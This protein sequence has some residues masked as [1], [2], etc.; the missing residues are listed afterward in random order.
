MSI[1]DQSFRQ[2]VASFVDDLVKCETTIAGFVN[3]TM[4]AVGQ[5]R[6]LRG[7]IGVGP[8]AAIGFPYGQLDMK[9]RQFRPAGNQ[10]FAVE[11]AM[12]PDYPTSRADGP[13]EVTIVE[14]SELL[15]LAQAAKP[16]EIG[17]LFMVPP[18]RHLIVFG[19]VVT[20]RGKVEVPGKHVVIFAR[21]LR[22]LADGSQKALLDASA[23]DP[24]DP[25]IP[26][27]DY[28]ATTGTA[29]ESARNEK[30][31]CEK[32]DFSGSHIS[33]TD[34][35]R[36]PDERA[37]QGLRGVDGK[38]GGRS[39][40]AIGPAG[41]DVFIVADSL[42]AYSDLTLC[43]SG[44]RG[45]RG[46]QGQDGGRGGPGGP[47]R[48]YQVYLDRSQQG[49]IYF[50][51]SLPGGPGGPG[52]DGGI[53]GPGGPGG[54]S[55]NC[56]ILMNKALAEGT[57]ID[58]TSRPGEAG[59]RGFHGEAG[60]IGDPGYNGVGSSAYSGDSMTTKGQYTAS[61]SGEERFKRLLNA[62]VVPPD[63]APPPPGRWG[64]FVVIHDFDAD[65]QHGTFEGL[66]GIARLSSLLMLLEAARARYLQWDAYRFAG[67][68]GA[69][70]IKDEL[71]ARLD[72]LALAASL[73]PKALSQSDAVVRDGI[74][75]TFATL[76]INLARGWDYFGHAE[77]YVPLGS[78]TISLGPFKDKVGLLDKREKTYVE[79]QQN[80]DEKKSLSE[81][82][83][84]AVGAALDD[85]K[86]QR[87]KVDDLRAELIHYIKEVIP[88]ATTK[89]A[90]SKVALIQTLGAFES[91]VK[92][93]SGLTVQ[94]YV[95]CLFNMAFINTEF[96]AF[97]TLVSQSIKLV[98]KA[99]NTL[100]ND[101]GQAVSRQHMLLRVDRFSK[102]LTRLDE[103]WETIKSATRSGDPEQVALHDPDAYR[104]LVEQ[105]EFNKL[106]EQ[107]YTRDEA[108][109]AMDAMDN[110]VE[111]IQERN[112]ILVEYNTGVTEYL[113]VAGE[114]RA[115]S[116]Q[117][118]QVLQLQADGADPNL[119]AETAFV[120]ALYNRTREE[121]I[122][123]CYEACRA[124]RFWTL[125]PDLALYET[126]KLGSPGVI[127]YQF[128]S[129][130]VEKLE[131]ENLTAK[132]KGDLQKNVNY[133]PSLED[134]YKGTGV[135][136]MLNPDQYP[137]EFRKL[138]QD[139][140]RG[141]PWRCRGS[142]SSASACDSYPRIGGA[143]SSRPRTCGGG[144]ECGLCP[145]MRRPLKQSIIRQE[146]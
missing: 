100:P 19:D 78:P 140:V 108:R 13:G 124:L 130:V 16:G 88:V 58:C 28:V 67:D 59:E 125:Q 7:G 11:D 54:P 105:D 9:D 26:S 122:Q 21:E 53:G 56:T 76:M 85:L 1:P 32:K 111:E 112:A 94:D 27:P 39:D 18:D 44:G 10:A 142:A 45:R 42:G 23:K 107:F 4:T 46:K 51:S 3:L 79:Y 15:V 83:A 115:T 117:K 90:S 43:S 64:R 91:W 116:A 25:G 118:D 41:G 113:R 62:N 50:H 99:E 34:Q 120:S 138:K 96:T 37:G 36:G 146:R 129:G 101:D 30:V 114:Y 84:A 86:N 137:H 109:A 52:G 66:R 131:F 33:G 104:L 63:L 92:T 48:N 73:L 145:A 47:G 29:G 75:A 97:T 134:D 95:D 128:L 89:V 102:R 136:V 6:T 35:D 71:Q 69:A 139:G 49:F 74:N 2:Y 82:R 65:A 103:A 57:Q 72:F 60:P 24:E 119:P 81:Q 31:W 22:T 126:F 106:L 61:Q 68:E 123:Y 132:I 8:S 98:D 93:C 143:S 14:S 55:G 144:P 127:D 12:T 5:G 121:C 87:E 70:R 77:N 80:L 40:D 17:R 110:Y 135:C 133:T 141:S 20:I 38:D